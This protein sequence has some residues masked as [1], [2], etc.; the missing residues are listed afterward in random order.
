ML[1][2]LVLRRLRMHCHLF[3]T[4]SVVPL[5][6]VLTICNTI[7][8]HYLTVYMMVGANIEDVQF[9]LYISSLKKVVVIEYRLYLIISFEEL[10]FQSTLI[11]N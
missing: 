5:I 7:I 3:Y 2:I 9:I 1:Y 4:Q 11:R 6:L 10:S 8:V